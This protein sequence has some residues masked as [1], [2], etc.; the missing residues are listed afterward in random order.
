MQ[1]VLGKQVSVV[2]RAA[3]PRDTNLAGTLEG[4]LRLVDSWIRVRGV[5]MCFVE[6]CAWCVWSAAT[7]RTAMHVPA[8][9]VVQPPCISS[10]LGFGVVSGGAAAMFA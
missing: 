3:A 8:M 4:Q 9:L 10:S 7:G 6:S 1:C 5:T 2:L